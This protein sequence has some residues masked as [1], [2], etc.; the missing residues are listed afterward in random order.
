MARRTTLSLG[1]KCHSQAK[2]T[3]G[4]YRLSPSVSA[5]GATYLDIFQEFSHMASNNPEE[6]KRRSLSFSHSCR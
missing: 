4:D 1:G 3:P 2:R 5:G 6:L